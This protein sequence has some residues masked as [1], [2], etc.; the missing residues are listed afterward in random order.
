MAIDTLFDR[1]SSVM[2]VISFITFAGILWWA[3]IHNKEADF[4]TAAQLP[5]DDEDVEKEAHHG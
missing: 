5:F 3:F 4:A 1:A 2:T